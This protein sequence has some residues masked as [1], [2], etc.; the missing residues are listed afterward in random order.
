MAEGWLACSLNQDT[1]AN[2]PY[3]NGRTQYQS[4]VQIPPF[5]GKLIVIKNVQGG[6]DQPDSFMISVTGS[7]PSLNSFQGSSS[8]TTILI[9]EGSYSVR[10]VAGP[11]GYTASYSPGCSGAMT[12][13]QTI[14]CTITNVPERAT[15]IVKVRAQCLQ[16]EVCPNL[17]VYTGMPDPAGTFI[18]FQPG[19]VNPTP[20]SFWGSE[21]GTSVSLGPGDYILGGSIRTPDGLQLVQLEPRSP[22]CGSNTSGPIGPGELRTCTWTNT[23]RP[24]PSG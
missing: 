18:F 10:E 7:N 21:A 15:L 13:G 11:G 17:P 12:G 6:S 2:Q 9:R 8:G 3:A 4:Q 16:G 1:Q 14:T 19:A 24:T 23:F 22:G 5:C 20:Q